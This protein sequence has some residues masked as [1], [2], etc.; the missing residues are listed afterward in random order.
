MSR[1][2]CITPQKALCM[3]AHCLGLLLCQSGLAIA[4]SKNH[5]LI[6]NEL[7]PSD[8]FR[9]LKFKTIDGRIVRTADL[10]GQ[11]V[12]VHYSGYDCPA[13]VASGE[14]GCETN[15]Q[16]LAHLQAKLSPERLAVINLFAD[17]NPA[18]LSK[19][20]RDRLISDY[21]NNNYYF[22][23]SKTIIPPPV[24]KK[25]LYSWP[26]VLIF[27]G[28]GRL[29]N[30]AAGWMEELGT[31]DTAN[32]I[33]PF[34]PRWRSLDLAIDPA[35]TRRFL[36]DLA[37]SGKMKTRDMRD[38]WMVRQFGY[39]RPKP[40]NPIEADARLQRARELAPLFTARNLYRQP[41]DGLDIRPGDVIGYSIPW[42]KFGALVAINDNYDPVNMV[43]KNVMTY[44]DDGNKLEL[45][46]R[47]NMS[48]NPETD[49]RRPVR[50]GLF[51]LR[52]NDLF[53]QRFCQ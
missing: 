27:D 5:G 32:A 47:L 16:G 18:D 30:K 49:L 4:E 25:Y 53:V 51:L 10:S 43:A 37:T 7:D 26:T 40:D 38:A 36:K 50:P 39:I 2:T 14:Y 45:S 23:G 6:Q 1:L 13:D 8:W 9:T 11:I 12:V 44:L 52:P 29:R 17:M 24:L 48:L 22:E 35:C 20:T 3:I 19:E 21:G 15:L 33:G 34:H 46:G 42:E 41:N 28:A 31:D